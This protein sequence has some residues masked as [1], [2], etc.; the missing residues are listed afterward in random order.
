MT[1]YAIRLQEEPVQNSPVILV[2][3]THVLFYPQRSTCLCVF[4]VL[5]KLFGRQS[6]V[7]HQYR[8]LAESD[9]GLQSHLHGR[10]SGT[11]D[12]LLSLVLKCLHL[13][14]NGL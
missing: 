7:P 11:Q 3:S 12:D 10:L 2:M 1:L 13:P 5:D 8:S 14:K 9:V 6:N 4:Y